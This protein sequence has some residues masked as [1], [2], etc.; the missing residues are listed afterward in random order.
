MSNKTAI[1]T[2][3]SRGIGRGIGLELARIG[4]DL[5]INYAGNQ[6]AALATVKATVETSS[7]EFTERVN[8]NFFEF[9]IFINFKKLQFGFNFWINIFLLIKS[10]S[11]FFIQ[12]L[13]SPV[14]DGH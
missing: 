14:N 13:F 5:I 1:I 10:Y 6:E 9:D 2:G 12:A 3:A 7:L 4:Y 8:T 11:L